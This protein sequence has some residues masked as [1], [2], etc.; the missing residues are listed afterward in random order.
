MSVKRTVLPVLIILICI[1]MLYSSANPVFLNDGPLKGKK[2]ILDAGH[3][4]IDGGCSSGTV[5]EKNINLSITMILKKKLQNEGCKVILTRSK[6]IALDNLNN[7]S[8]ARHIRDLIARVDIIND[9][10]PDLFL[11]IHVNSGRPSSKGCN[12]FYYDKYPQSMI[13]ASYIQNHLNKLTGINRTI[14]NENFYILKY[15]ESI[16]ALVEVGFLTNSEEKTLLVQR[17]Y[18]N[19]IADKI[20]SAIEDYFDNDKYNNIDI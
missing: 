3:G 10:D 16:G 8:S 13:L 14:Q 6:D 7:K 19:K 2:I 1:F 18:Q 20:L 4:G 11:S 9:H 5:L 15:S 12:V 17:S